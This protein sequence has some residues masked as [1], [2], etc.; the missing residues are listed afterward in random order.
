MDGSSA[1]GPTAPRIPP[2]WFPT[3]SRDRRRDNAV[4]LESH[5]TMRKSQA[6]PE[7]SDLRVAEGG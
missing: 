7:K 6:I 5:T 1:P 4:H 3:R 2:V